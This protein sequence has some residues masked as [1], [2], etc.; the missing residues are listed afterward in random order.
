MLKCVFSYSYD[1]INNSIEWQAYL[2][3]FYL[4]FFLMREDE[5]KREGPKEEQREKGGNRLSLKAGMD[6]EP[7]SEFLFHFCAQD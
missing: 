1:S 4:F 7:V 6:P 3:V 2:Y 5:G